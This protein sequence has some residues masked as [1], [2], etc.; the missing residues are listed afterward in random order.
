MTSIFW[1]GDQKT[2]IKHTEFSETFAD[3]PMFCHLVKKVQIW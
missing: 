1:S 2:Q 3:Q